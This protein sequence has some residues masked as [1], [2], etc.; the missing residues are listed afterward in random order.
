M[1]RPDDLI[2]IQPSK[3][4]RK[5]AWLPKTHVEIRVVAEN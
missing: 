5:R 1:Q 3:A 2:D 4:D